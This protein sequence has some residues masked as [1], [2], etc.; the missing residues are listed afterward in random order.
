M[1]RLRTAASAHV[2]ASPSG[3]IRDAGSLLSVALACRVQ[4][5][6]LLSTVTQCRPCTHADTMHRRASGVRQ[7]RP[8]S[9]GG[10]R[11]EHHSHSTRRTPA[12]IVDYSAREGCPCSMEAWTRTPLTSPNSTGVPKVGQLRL[13]RKCLFDPYNCPTVCIIGSYQRRNTWLYGRH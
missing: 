2:A 8:S 13:S 1:G 9:K 4:T 6:T 7:A 10:D 5:D 11:C 3:G 12:R